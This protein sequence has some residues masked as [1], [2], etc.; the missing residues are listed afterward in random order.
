MHVD[1]F[2]DSNRSKK[3]F[4]YTIVL[5]VCTSVILF[6]GLRFSDSDY[7]NLLAALFSPGASS[8]PPTKGYLLEGLLGD[9]IG[10]AYLSVGL[11]GLAAQFAWWISGLALPAAVIAYSIENRST[12]IVDVVLIVAF[13]PLERVKHGCAITRFRRGSLDVLALPA[14]FAL[15]YCRARG[16]DYILDRDPTIFRATASL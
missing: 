11:R 10:L 8:I 6:Q 4:A 15:S 7:P 13:T 9:V 14:R 5:I 3:S 12:S 2:L 1:C 16:L